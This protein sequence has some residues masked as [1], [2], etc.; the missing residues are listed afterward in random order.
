MHVYY[1]CLLSIKLSI[2]TK[3]KEGHVIGSLCLVMYQVIE[4]V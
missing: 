2:I 1:H 4:E 3:V